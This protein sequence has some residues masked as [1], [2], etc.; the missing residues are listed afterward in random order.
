[1]GVVRRP[2][3]EPMIGDVDDHR[4][5]SSWSIV[6]DRDVKGLTVIIEDIAPGDRI[7][8]HTHP[9]EEAMIV[10]TGAP[11]VRV[12]R[13]QRVV[14]PGAVMLIPAQ[15]PHGAHNVTE[16]SGRVHAVFPT[17]R[18]GVTS[19]ERNPAPGTRAHPP[20]PPFELDLSEGP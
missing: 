2:T 4:P 9:S 8:L 16:E 3:F 13:D 5:K 17:R 14:G 11:R 7:P 18:I 1:M 10:A 15:M 12:G 6:T 20:Q 19:L